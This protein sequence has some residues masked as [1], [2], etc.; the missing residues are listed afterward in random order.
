MR[1]AIFLFC[2]RNWREMRK[3]ATMWEVSFFIRMFGS[4]QGRKKKRDPA[5]EAQAKERVKASTGAG[6]WLPADAAVKNALMKHLRP[7]LGS[8]TAGDHPLPEGVGD[9]EE[10]G[11]K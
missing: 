3:A 6:W 7:C 10:N 9:A 8:S 11:E 4:K 1:G 2:E 5:P